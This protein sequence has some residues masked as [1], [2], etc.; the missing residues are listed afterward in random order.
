[1]LKKPTPGQLM[2]MGSQGSATDIAKGFQYLEAQVLGG[3]TKMPKGTTWSYVD[4]A[5][6]P[7]NRQN[8][9]GGGNLTRS[10]DTILNI[11]GGNKSA[12][13]TF[14][15]ADQTGLTN[16]QQMNDFRGIV[17]E[18][19]NIVKNNP[20]QKLPANFS[21]FESLTKRTASLPK[22][23][24]MGTLSKALG[25]L[26]YLSTIIDAGNIFSGKKKSPLDMRDSMYA[27][28][29]LVKP[30]YFNYG[31]MVKAYARGG[32]VVPSMLTPGEFVMSKYAVQNYGVDKMKSMNNGTY[33][34][35]SVYNYNLSVNVTSDANPDDIARTVMTQIKQVESQRIRS[36]R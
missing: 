27:M 7:V 28:G 4:P 10:L 14:R 17:K 11:S 23:P 24:F 31:G 26:G 22:L 12:M 34:G 29:G 8:L 6:G 33:N 30:K 21:Q 35:D 19:K 18:T 20:T 25:P 13:K 15:F 16:R 9:I 36:A 2:A 1:M 5:R 3:A 32:D